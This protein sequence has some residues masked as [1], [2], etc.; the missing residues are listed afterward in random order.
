MAAI[1]SSA[2]LCWAGRT[3]LTLA[4]SSSTAVATRT[5]KDATGIGPEVFSWN[6]TT[7]P[8][9]QTEFYRRAGFWIEVPSYDLRPE[10]IESYY[11]A[12]RATGDSK[13]QDWAW[14]GFQAINASTRAASGFSAI[15]D[16]NTPGGGDKLDNQESF[17]FAEVMKYSYLI[18]AAV[19]VPFLLLG[20]FRGRRCCG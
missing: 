5:R 19:S 11:Y 17:L 13:Y 15:S 10:V 16:V 6:T 1:L 7:L 2:A 12:Y 20:S 8:A 9:N 18:F 14:E 3:T 4:S